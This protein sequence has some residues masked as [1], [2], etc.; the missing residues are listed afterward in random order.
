MG[1]VNAE[2]HCRCQSVRRT[3]VQVQV[4][5]FGTHRHGDKAEKRKALVY[6]IDPINTAD[7]RGEPPAI[8][9]VRIGLGGS[10]RLE[11]SRCFSLATLCTPHPTLRGTAVCLGHPGAA[12]QALSSLHDLVPFDRLLPATRRLCAGH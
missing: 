5:V 11:T 2:F 10:G 12:A 3:I 1:L 6:G 4:Q 9:L 8:R 7:R